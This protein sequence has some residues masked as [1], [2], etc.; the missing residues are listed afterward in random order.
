[1]Q[2]LGQ[3][4]PWGF[5]PSSM[6]SLLRVLSRKQLDQSFILGKLLL[7]SWRMDSGERKLGGI[8]ERTVRY[9]LSL[10]R[11]NGGSAEEEYGPKPPCCKMGETLF[12]LLSVQTVP[13]GVLQ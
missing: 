3:H 13:T 11:Y 1:M 2:G 4:R 5:I 10:A 8:V 9:F 12:L 7:T 6:E